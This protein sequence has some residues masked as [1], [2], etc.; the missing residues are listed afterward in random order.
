MEKLKAK[1][2]LP[3]CT[4]STDQQVGARQFT[5]RDKME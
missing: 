2:Q 5:A 1:H 3:L 4:L